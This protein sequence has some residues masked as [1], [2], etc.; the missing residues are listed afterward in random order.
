M[1]D[2]PRVYLVGAGPGDPELLTLKALRLLQEADVVVYDR[3]VSPEVLDLI[4]TGTSKIYVGKA[5]NNHT[6]PQ[7]EINKL[8]VKLS[9]A[10][11]RVVRLK[12][13]DPYIFG[14]G[15]EEAL[16]LIRLGIPFEVVP[17]ITAAS[18]AAAVGIPLTHRQLA[19]GV[20]FVTGHCREDLPLDLNWD[21]LA[22]PD[23]TLVI[24]MGMA[25][26]KEISDNLVRAGLE[27]ST[28]AAAVSRCSLPDQKVC[29]AT[30]G[31]LADRVVETGLKGPVL[32]LIG[33]TVG[34]AGVLA[35]ELGLLYDEKDG[36]EKIG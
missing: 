24:Y 12:G 27:A 35:P 28:P 20:R 8:L 2:S 3:L 26:L 6:M 13:G 23:T 11:H 1:N 14:R 7:D 16:E 25:N 10:R 18:G 29:L 22:D 9:Q 34:L 32:T 15:S 4:P 5:T 36:M 33:K 21:S 19:T 30:L 17:G 31:S